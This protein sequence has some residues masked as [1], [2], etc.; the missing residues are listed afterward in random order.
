MQPEVI[1]AL[2]S[3]V[4]GMLSLVTSVL[5]ALLAHRREYALQRAEIK[6]SEQRMKVE[7]E[8]KRDQ[9]Q[10]ELTHE[11]V[12]WQESFRAELRRQ[13]VQESTLEVVKARMQLYGEVWR[14]LKITSGHEWRLLDNKQLAVKQ[15]A[16]CLTDFAYSEVGMFMSDRSRRLLNNL[17]TGSGEFL[18]GAITDLEL[19][20]R[21]H[22]LNHSLRSDLGIITYEYE[23]GLDEA[24][25][26]LGRVDDWSKVDS[27]Q[28]SKP[29]GTD[30]SSVT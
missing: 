27:K 5:I 10:T 26:R 20:T 14:A 19:R 12:H 2:I 24:A 29:N 15:M 28:N 22:L 21:A 16:N 25:R 23:S 13:L 17:R 18:D 3:G 11:E 4:I 6:A 8:S 30:A 7:I 1:A 9:W